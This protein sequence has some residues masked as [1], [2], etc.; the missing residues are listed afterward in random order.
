MGSC[1]V[2]VIPFISNIIMRKIKGLTRNLDPRA[3]L[4]SF[5]IIINKIFIPIKCCIFVYCL[6]YAY[7]TICGTMLYL[8]YVTGNFS[9]KS[10]GFLFFRITV[11][12]YLA[13][14]SVLGPLSYLFC[15]LLVIYEL[16]FSKVLPDIPL[17]P[18]M[19][20]NLVLN[21]FTLDIDPKEWKSLV[22]RM[23]TKARHLYE[24]YGGG[25]TASRALREI[26]ATRKQKEVV[27]DYIVRI[28]R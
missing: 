10:M 15:D 28:A 18:H 22:D 16:I 23:E 8:Q 19:D 12:T 14:Y 11:F 5:I 27:T 17:I 13:R 3:L 26:G 1:F 9:L 7:L 6:F 4:I 24:L 20:I 21:P 2:A 25:V